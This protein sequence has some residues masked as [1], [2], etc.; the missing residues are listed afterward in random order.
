MHD[1]YRMLHKT[2]LA[3][4]VFNVKEILLSLLQ[5]IIQI[6][7]KVYSRDEAELADLLQKNLKRKRYL[8]VMDDIWSYKAWDDMRQCFPIDNNGSRILLTT[9]HTEVAL[10]AS[11]NNLLLKMNLMKSD[12]SWNLFKRKAFANE[13]FPRDKCHFADCKQMNSPE[14]CEIS[15]KRLVRLWIAEGFLKL[16]GDLEEEAEN[17]L[18]DLVDRCLVLA[19]QKSADG[20]KIKTCRVHDLVNELCLRE[21]QRENFLFIRNDE[22]ETVPLVGCRLIRIQKRRQTGVC[23]HDENFYKSL[24]LE[25]IVLL[26]FSAADTFYRFIED[27]YEDD[28]VTT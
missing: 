25:L 21:A 22:T 3:K 2:T 17:R 12:E 27:G 26:R 20:R 9:C 11:S 28:R 13:I 8:I 15:V 6:D 16:D 1:V 5:S 7:D 14:D 4:Q 23:F 10:Y 18:Q 24:R 19:S